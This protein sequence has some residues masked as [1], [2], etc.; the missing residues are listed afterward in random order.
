MRRLLSYVL[1]H[2]LPALLTF[3]F[4]C[5]GFLLSFVYPFIIG[6]VVD[7]S[8]A[9]RESPARRAEQLLQLTVLAALTGACHAI[10][11]YG[12]GHFNVQLGTAVVSDLRRDLFAH[13]QRMSIRFFAGRRVGTLL[14]RILHDVHDATALI[15]MGIVVAVL[16]A[17]QLALAVVLLAGISLKLTLACVTV[18]PL[19]GLVFSRMNPRVRRASERV[20]ESMAQ[21]S[22]HTAER[23]AGQALVKTYCAEAREQAAFTHAVAHHQDLVIAESREGHRV[24]SWGEVLV[25][26]GT[27]IVVSYGG[28]LAINGELTPGRLTRFLGFVVILYGP[29]RRFAELSTVYQSSLSAL[30][31]VFEVLDTEPAVNEPAGARTSPPR[32]GSIRF[33]EVYFRYSETGPEA[34]VWLDSELLPGPAADARPVLDGIT[35]EV[36]A[37]E[38]VAIVGP[39]GAGKTTLA[40]LVPRLFDPTSGRVLVDGTDVRAYSL[41]ALRS[42][43]AIVQQEALLFTGT[44]RDNIAYGRP[45]ATEREIIEAAQAAHAH[46]FIAAL[47]HGYESLLGERG[48]N[49]SGGQRQRLSIARALLKDPQVLILD[50]ATSSLDAE[51]EQLVQAALERLMRGRTSLIIAHRMKTVRN[52]D[53]IVVLQHG[54]VSEAGSHAE[55]M[56]RTGL[57]ERYVRQQSDGQHAAR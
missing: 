29:V 55:L 6:E 53:R 40:S 16:D 28:Y 38:R 7:L 21:I 24:I 12:R 1:R 2:P 49:L 14:A 13:V 23:L 46:E 3:G 22:G 20:R 36:A 9:G 42:S 39:S 17:A 47:P 33:E 4:G 57:Y 51:T 32:R 8:I 19:Y 31:R 43:I 44:I 11:L 52:A 37:G 15:Y 35:F 10:V 45:A 41:A 54:R 18:F 26:L 25:H 27:T 50:E 48:V 30:R 34:R 5:A 56:R